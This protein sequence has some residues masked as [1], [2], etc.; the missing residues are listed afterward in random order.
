[1]PSAY[2]ESSNENGMRQDWTWTVLPI[3]RPGESPTRQFFN[4][5]LT[6]TTADS[7][8][9]WRT[10]KHLLHSNDTDRTLTAAECQNVCNTLSNYFLD[11]ITNIKLAILT[12]LS[13]IDISLFQFTAATHV[14]PTLDS[15]PLVTTAEISCILSKIPGKSCPLDFIPTSLVKSCSCVFSEI[16]AKLANLSFQQGCF[17]SVFKQAL[18][19]PLIKKTWSRS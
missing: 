6:D 10:V 7:K 8:Q 14:G 19:T 2:V 16:I 13:T 11:K 5:E 3:V 9:R 18:V 4:K 17:P 12:K 1:M 15:I